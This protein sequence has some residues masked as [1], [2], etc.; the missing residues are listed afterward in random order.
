MQIL[1]N[2]A[3]HTLKCAMRFTLCGGMDMPD[4]VLAETGVL[5]KLSSVRVKLLCRYLIDNLLGNPLRVHFLV[6][7]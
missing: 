7:S 6:Y 2:H 5:S 3:I 1:A 4:W